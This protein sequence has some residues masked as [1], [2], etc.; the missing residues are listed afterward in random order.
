MN[1]FK[2]PQNFPQDLLLI[3]DLIG[4]PTDPPPLSPRISAV[5]QLTDDNGIDSSD[6]EIASEDEIEAE[7]IPVG[8]EDDLKGPRAMHVFL[9]SLSM[10]LTDSIVQ[11]RQTQIQIQSR[12]LA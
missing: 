1:G 2:L 11:C 12:R 9:S 3:C 10:P 7:L 6:S 8:Y 5:V 4:V